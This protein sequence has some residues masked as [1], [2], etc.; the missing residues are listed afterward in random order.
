MEVQNTR[1]QNSKLFLTLTFFLFVISPVFAAMPNLLTNSGW[2]NDIAGWIKDDYNVPDTAEAISYGEKHTYASG[3][4]GGIPRLSADFGFACFNLADNGSG[5][6]YQI[7]GG[8]KPNTRYR[9]SCW[10]YDVRDYK[11]GYAVITWFKTATADYFGDALNNTDPT[12]IPPGWSEKNPY[13]LGPS[14]AAS[15]EVLTSANWLLYTNVFTAPSAALS[16]QVGTFIAAYGYAYTFYD[17]M[18]FG[19]LDTISPL[20]IGNLTVD[21]IN[22]RRVKLSWTAPGDNGAVDDFLNVTGVSPK[23][24]VRYSTYLINNSTFPWSSATN[25]IGEPVPSLCG[26]TTSY[27]VNGLTNGVTYYFAI[28]TSDD[29]SNLSDISN[30]VSA[31]PQLPR[32]TINPVAWPG[33]Y[34]TITWQEVPNIDHYEVWGGTDPAGLSLIKSISFSTMTVFVDTGA[35]AGTRYYYKVKAVNVGPTEIA[36]S[37]LEVAEYDPTAPTVSD[38]AVVAPKTVNA[39]NQIKI[40]LNFTD[41]RQIVSVRGYWRKKGESAW[42]SISITPEIVQPDYP[43]NYVGEAVIP[44]GVVSGGAIEYYFEVSDGSQVSYFPAG[45]PSGIYYNIGISS[46]TKKIL[47]PGVPISF[48]ENIKEVKVYSSSGRLVKQIYRGSARYIVWNG[49]DDNDNVLESGAYIF[50][51]EKDDGGYE[52][53]TLVI[54]K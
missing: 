32:P 13:Y 1:N 7:V 30:I 25:P 18:Y 33:Q 36:E 29:H 20:A 17:N 16:A 40:N 19:E 31:C 45:A 43:K 49:K 34:P 44:A 27:N 35:V 53:G 11:K 8:V 10:M 48:A 23:F 41:N 39:Y 24:D 26:L 46:R 2:E 14:H 22:N 9:F 15:K 42:Q 54:A 37:I 50:R 52:T 5:Y 28:R 6:V 38:M 21:K 51:A 12:Y 3:S 47:T 4:Y